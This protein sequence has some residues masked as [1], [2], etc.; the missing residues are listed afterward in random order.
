[1]YN[2]SLPT[3]T[4]SCYHG[5]DLVTCLIISNQNNREECQI[6][7]PTANI[8]NTIHFQLYHGI[9]S[10]TS[11]KAVIDMINIRSTSGSLKNFQ[12]P[13]TFNND[14]QLK[15]IIHGFGGNCGQTW[16][17]EMITNLILHQQVN[18]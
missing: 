11:G 13:Q 7:K 1:M 10:N 16:V 6:Q 3:V 18:M 2:E 9:I 17:Q 5:D 4:H 14:L 15:I 12:F 8:S